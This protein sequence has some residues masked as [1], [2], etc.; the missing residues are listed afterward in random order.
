[1]RK[2]TSKKTAPRLTKTTKRPRKPFVEPEIVEQE[3]L[4]RVI[5]QDCTVGGSPLCFG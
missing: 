4:K 2:K 1:M 3:P 5:Q